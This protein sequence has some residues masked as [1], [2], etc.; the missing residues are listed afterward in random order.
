[1]YETP[2]DDTIKKITVTKECVTDGKEP[3]IERN[4]MELPEDT[5]KAG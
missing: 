4:V 2:S 3:V 5:N 1:M